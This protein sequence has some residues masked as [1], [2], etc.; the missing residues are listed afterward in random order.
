MP[1]RLLR[2]GLIV[3]DDWSYL[4]E[5]EGNPSAALILTLADWQTD[6][7]R[8]WRAAGVW[9]WCYRRLTRWNCWRPISRDSP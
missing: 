4:A 6:L 3:D 2:D 1:R 5:A 7:K 8:G 9:G